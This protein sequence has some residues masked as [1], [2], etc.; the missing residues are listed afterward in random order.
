M[1]H[2]CWQKFVNIW[3]RLLYLSTSVAWYLYRVLH[4]QNKYFEKRQSF[5]QGYL[6]SH[7]FCFQVNWGS[8]ECDIAV[9]SY[10][11]W[12]RWNRALSNFTKCDI[13][14]AEKHKTMTTKSN[15]FTWQIP[16]S[17]Q[18][19]DRYIPGQVCFVKLKASIRVWHLAATP[20]FPV[21]GDSGKKYYLIY[22]NRLSLLSLLSLC[23]T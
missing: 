15:L 23:Y 4:P 2:F 16:L 9:L 12:H 11:Y 18:F 14:V 17:N 13:S 7:F 10:F 5:P 8:T 19:H 3:Q 6:L 1:V 21:D 22:C 20:F